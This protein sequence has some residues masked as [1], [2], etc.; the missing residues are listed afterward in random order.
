MDATSSPAG[1]CPV[2]SDDRIRG[3]AAELIGAGSMVQLPIRA[4]TR[5]EWHKRIRC[6]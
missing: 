6:G 2:L 1:G 4:A 5:E 3:W